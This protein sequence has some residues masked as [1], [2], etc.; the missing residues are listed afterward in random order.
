MSTFIPHEAPPSQAGPPPAGA[1]RVSYGPA[2]QHFGDLRLPGSRTGRPLVV[3]V[4]GGA[5]RNAYHLDLME[6]LA[7]DLTRRGFPTWSIEYRRAGDPGAEWPGLFADVAAAADR[8]VALAREHG[9]DPGKA[10][11]LG[12][13]AGGH[14]ALW[15][16][17]RHRG[18][19]FGPGALAVGGVVAVAPVTDLARCRADR[20]Y[21]RP[22]FGP[23]DAI[24]PYRLLPTGVRQVVVHGAADQSVAVAE[25]RRYV[26][27]ARAAGDDA[28]L[29]EIPGAEH[30]A[31][32]TVG[33]PAWEAVAAAVEALGKG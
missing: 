3:V 6:G 30:F 26:E 19:G 11:A 25:S 32:I 12:H 4:H 17:G 9:L 15:L 18:A 33:Q 10:I 7:A 14:L 22:L 31:P 20:P 29:I 24:D 21:V 8:V 23:P 16:A 2:P 13:C 28:S 5:Y 27:A 1:L